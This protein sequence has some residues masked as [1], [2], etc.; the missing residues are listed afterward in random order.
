MYPFV[1]MEKPEWE[2]KL[3]VA[4]YPMTRLWPLGVVRRHIHFLKA[5]KE[6]RDRMFKAYEDTGG[7]YYGA[8]TSEEESVGASENEGAD[9][10]TDSEDDADAVFDKSFC[11]TA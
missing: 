11:L 7:D 8:E 2:A 5:L 10:P 4:N 1:V 6:H 9:D 3:R